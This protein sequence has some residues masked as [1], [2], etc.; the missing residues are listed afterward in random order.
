VDTGDLDLRD[1]RSCIVSLVVGESAECELSMPRHRSK[2]K[3]EQ[4]HL[5]I[6]AKCRYI[7]AI[8]LG[9]QSECPRIT[10]LEKGLESVY[11]CT[12]RLI[13]PTYSSCKDCVSQLLEKNEKKRLG[14]RCGAS[15]V[16]QHKWFA[17]INWGLLRNTR[18]PVRLSI[19]QRGGRVCF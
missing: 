18:P 10:D 5:R 19:I 1:D 15:E 17:K 13:N 7:S 8:L 14:S 2:A 9:S 12:F 16:K 6:Y 11:V 3:S 4:I